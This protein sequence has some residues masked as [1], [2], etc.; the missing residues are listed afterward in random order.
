MELAD[1]TEPFDSVRVH[2]G[3]LLHDR[4]AIHQRLEFVF[5]DGGQ[6][7]DDILNVARKRRSPFISQGGSQASTQSWA[8]RRTW[9]AGRPT[10]S[11]TSTSPL[12]RPSNLSAPSM[13]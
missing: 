2:R 1:H 3:A 10:D 9:L 11:A 12:Q 7:R 6:I 5:I 8:S 4:Q 13:M